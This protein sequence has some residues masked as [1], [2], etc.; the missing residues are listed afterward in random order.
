MSSRDLIPRMKPP[1][2]EHFTCWN[3]NLQ[4]KTIM[5]WG[6]EGHQCGKGAKCPKCEALQ[7]E[8]FRPVEVVRAQFG[9]LGRAD[10]DF[11]DHL[12]WYANGTV[13]MEPYQ[14]DAD[15]IQAL[16]KACESLG[17]KMDVRGAPLPGYSQHNPACIWIAIR[18]VN[19]R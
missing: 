10:P 9:M 13:T 7:H 4:T 14:L 17:F 18:K 2:A 19:D 12:R 15:K 5:D 16:S 3:C 1:K 8:D 11:S 6:P